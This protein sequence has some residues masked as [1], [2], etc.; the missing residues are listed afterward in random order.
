MS[1]LFTVPVKFSLL[2]VDPV[3]AKVPVPEM[4]VA[5][6]VPTARHAARPVNASSFGKVMNVSKGYQAK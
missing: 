1:A 4:M 2:V 6:A 5:W 3:S